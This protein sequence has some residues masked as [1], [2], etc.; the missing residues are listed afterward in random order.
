MSDKVFEALT[1]KIL[2][3]LEAGVVPWQ[4]PWN[5]DAGW[6][7]NL[8]S[9]RHYSGFNVFNLTLTMMEA[10]YQHNIWVTF[11]QCSDMGGKIRKG[12]GHAAKVLFH[13]VKHKLVEDDS[14]EMV[15]KPVYISPRYTPVWNIAQT[16]GLEDK[17]GKFLEK[18]G[19]NNEIPEIE[20]GEQVPQAVGVQVQYGGGKAAYYPGSD[21]IVMPI[22][23]SFKSV[24]GF[25]GTLFHEVGHAT[26]HGDRLNR[27]ELVGS[28]G[29]GGNNYSREE[30]TAE[31]YA[32]FMSSLL[33]ISTEPKFENNA[34]YIASWLKKLQDD[35]KMLINA[36][37]DAEAA[38][39]WTLDKLGV[40]GY[41]SDVS[42]ETEDEPE[43]EVA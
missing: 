28:D 22:R 4:K 37:K 17:I 3:Q 9:G 27:P 13:A 26:G 7:V 31:M 11:K 32:V 29:F 10:G 8:R 35:R 38:V 19:Q 1:D 33:G 36:A 21:Q 18:L 23:S 34:S 12:E 25:Y 6:P 40:E 42:I 20:D 41:N 43:L 16:E 15:R 24:E 5:P 30:L 2:A 14:G 39:R